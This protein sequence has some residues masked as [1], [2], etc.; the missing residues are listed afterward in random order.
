MPAIHGGADQ[1][2]ID[3]LDEEMVENDRFKDRS[4]AL[5]YCLQYTLRVKYNADI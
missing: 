2:V 3:A 4:E 5:E 1:E